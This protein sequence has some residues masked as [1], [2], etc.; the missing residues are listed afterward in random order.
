MVYLRSG[1]IDLAIVGGT[2]S[3][4]DKMA[5]YGF[6]KT[7]A[8]ALNQTLTDGAIPFSQ[9]SSGFAISEGSGVV[10]LERE[11]SALKRD[12]LILGEIENVVSNN[13]GVS[14]YTIDNTG[15]QM[16]KALHK[17]IRDRKPDYNKQSGVRN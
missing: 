3:L 9:H 1:M 15:E 2:D 17:V 8:I 5:T 7:K 12:V 14:I 16:I 4:V 11:E 6:A 10:I 13:D